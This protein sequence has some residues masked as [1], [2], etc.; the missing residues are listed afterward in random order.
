MIIAIFFIHSE[1]DLSICLYSFGFI[2]LKK[3]NLKSEDNFTN[4][5]AVKYFSLHFFIK[6]TLK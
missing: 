4:V 6:Y 3:K 2:W 1:T 5:S